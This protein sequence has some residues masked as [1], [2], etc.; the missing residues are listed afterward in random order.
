MIGCTV[1]LVQLMKVHGLN[2]SNYNNVFATESSRI[3]MNTKWD[4]Y[5]YTI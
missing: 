1:S 5:Y 3:F 2:R 4:V